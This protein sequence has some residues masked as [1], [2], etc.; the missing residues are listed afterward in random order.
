MKISNSIGRFVGAIALL[1]AVS[2]FLGAMPAYAGYWSLTGTPKAVFTATGGGFGGATSGPTYTANSVKFQSGGGGGG[3][4]LTGSLTYTGTIKWVPANANDPAPATATITEYGYAYAYSENGGAPTTSANDGLGDPVTK[5]P[6]PGFYRGN[7]QQSVTGSTTSTTHV[8]KV[9][10]P[11]GGTYTLK[12][13]ESC[14][15]S[16]PTFGGSLFIKEVVN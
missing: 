12:H 2:T 6:V 9:S 15:A 8:Y 16:G 14:S 13:N 11:A 7:S 10:V 1:G 4:S 5:G 3:T